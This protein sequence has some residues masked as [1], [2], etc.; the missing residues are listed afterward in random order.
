ML[1]LKVIGS[2]ALALFGDQPEVL[3][4]L[5]ADTVS[6]FVLERALC[7]VQNR[8]GFV[9]ELGAVSLPVFHL[10]FCCSGF[11]LWFVCSLVLQR[12][13]QI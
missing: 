10:D 12:I 1:V 5:H 2:N 4:F 9:L 13:E 11:V 7:H 6:V 8:A 3:D